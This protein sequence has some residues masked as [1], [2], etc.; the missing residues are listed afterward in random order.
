MGHI[1]IIANRL[2]KGEKEM[3][4]FLPG[5]IVGFREG[6]E[7]LMVVMFLVQYL[8]RSKHEILLKNVYIGMGLGIAVSMAAGGLLFL[9]SGAIEDM[10]G[11]TGL[12]ES[13]ASLVALGFVT[14]F[15]YWMISHGRDM[16]AS[17]EGNVSSRMTAAGVASVAM[18]MV[19]REGLEMAVFSFAGKYTVI[20]LAAGILCALLVTA[21]VLFSFVRVNMRVLFNVTL[22]Y[23]IFQAGFLLGFVIHEGLSAFLAMN[24]LTG[25]SPLLVSLYDLSGTVLN[26]KQGIIG[27]PLYV[28]FGWNSNPEIL[29]FLAQYVFTASF[30]AIWHITAKKSATRR[31]SA[32]EA[33]PSH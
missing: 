21:L 20:S 5:L 28:L 29:Q 24:L 25:D 27:L 9:L 33:H 2:A 12:W 13:G 17:I 16:A 23:L 3:D 1:I 18:A 22:A 30:L 32:L 10:E 15:I 4:I 11:F 19:A 7:A 31:Q 14:A 26:H 6:L 8:K